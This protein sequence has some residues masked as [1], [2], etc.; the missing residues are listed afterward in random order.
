MDS[1]DRRPAAASRWEW[2]AVA[3]LG[4]LGAVVADQWFGGF[5]LG[6]PWTSSDFQDYCAG[7]WSLWTDVPEAF[8][9]KRS[10]L[11][12]VLAAWTGADDVVTALQRGAWLGAAGGFVGLAAWARVLGGRGAAVVAV[13][14]AWAVAPLVL[15]SR[16]YTFYPAMNAVLVGGSAV[17]AGA[18]VQPRRATLAAAG[19]A[20]GLAL[21]IDV[22]G[23]LWA[24]PWLLALAAVGLR[25]APDRGLRLLSLAVPVALSFGLGAW[26][27]PAE[28][29]SLEQQLDVRPLAAFRAGGEETRAAWDYGSRFVWGQ[30]APWAVVGTVGFLLANQR[31]APSTLGELTDFAPIVSA[32]LDPWLPPLA[33]GLL[34]AAVLMR[35]RPWPALALGATT[36]PFLLA[37]VAARSS[38]EL[39]LR[40]LSQALVVVPLVVGVAAGRALDAGQSRAR[41]VAGAV[42]VAVLALAV[43]GAVPSPLSP[44]A[45]WRRTWPPNTLDYMRTTHHN[46]YTHLRP[47]FRTCR[48]ALGLPVPDADAGGGPAPQE[49]RGEAF[50]PVSPPIAPR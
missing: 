28:A 16:M 45:E 1:P 7:V 10:R 14:L 23:V 8:P 29:L 31:A 4:L 17:V 18:V 11:A 25:P 49:L 32:H 30:S 37:L 19:A 6:G 33:V 13:V 2:L 48:V 9:V 27:F 12:G 3:G 47:A 43:F 24:G 39:Q 5:H 38:V 40:F 34:G 36:L 42:A 26:A 20:V 41:V 44:R 15:G 21:C 50:Q 35:R 22:R 46:A